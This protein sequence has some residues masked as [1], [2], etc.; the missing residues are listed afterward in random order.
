MNGKGLRKSALCI[1]LGMCLS[2]A[3]SLQSAHAANN[4]GSLVGRTTPGAQV[5]VTSPDTG[6][7]RTVTADEQGNYRFPFLPVGNYNVAVSSDGA[8]VGEARTVTISLGN[9]TNLTV[10][11]ATDLAAVQVL[12]SRVISPIDVTSTESATNITRQEVARLPVQRDI[13]DVATLAPGVNRGEFGGISFGGSSVAEN[14][15]YINGLNVTDFYNRVG[16]SSLPFSFLQEFQIK[17]GGY[18]VE[19]GRTT[20]GVINA[21]TRSGSNEFHAGAD[22]V[23]DGLMQSEA[24]DHTGLIS[25]YDETEENNYAVWASGPIIKDRLF[26]FGIYEKRDLDGQNTNDG[27]TRFFKT[28]GNNDFWGAKLDWQIND[29]NLLELLAFSDK[30]DTTQDSYPF[31]HTT[32][33]RGERDNRTFNKNGGDN[34]ALTYTGYLT[35]ALSMKVLYGENERNASVNS[36]NDAACN[37]VQDRRVSADFIGCTSNT[38]VI[39]RTDTREAARIDFEWSLGEHLLRFGADHENN[40]SDY[41]SVYPGNGLRYEVSNIPASRRVNGVIVPDPTATAYVR[42]RQ[43]ANNGTFETENEA[44]YVEDNW[45]VTPNLVLNLGLRWEAFDNKD[46]EGRSYIEMDD[47]IAPRFGFSWDFN[48]DGRAKIF[49]NAGRYYLPVAN[50][51][52]IKQAGPFLDAR[53]FFVFQGFGTFTNPSTGITYP[54][55]ILGQEIGT[56]DDSQGDGT[57]GDLTGEVDQDMDPV[58]QD[59]YILGF[60]QMLGETWSWGVRGIYR[61]LHDAIDDMEITYNGFCEVDTFVMANPGKDLTFFTDTD[62]D[63]D[64]DNDA[65]VTIDTSSQGWALYND[66]GDLVGQRGWGQAKRT[67]RALEFVL[68]RAWDD[69]WAFNASYTLSYSKG[70]AEGP[71]NSDTDFADSGRTE[72]FDNPFVNLDGYGYLPNDHRHQFKFRAS[73]ALADNWLLGGTLDAQSGRPVSEFGAGNPIDSTEFL[74]HYICEFN[75]TEEFEPSERIYRLSPRG[76]YDRLPWAYSL[77]A[78]IA[79]NRDFGRVKMNAKFA[80]YNITNEQTVTEVNETRE[81]QD[82]IGTPNPFFFQGTGYQAPRYAQFILSINY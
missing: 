2:S 9:A 69:K 32:G 63:C 22:L 23:F 18:S 60:Q 82:G 70:N 14:S 26:F 41:S 79:Y 49:G 48:G 33:D 36:L 67:Y 73:Y 34:W 66:D 16:F 39:D 72:A 38:A 52:N 77:G 19:F 76:A 65:M 78:S 51:I 42:T 28:D 24:K 6:F 21:V 62:P 71:V 54:D 58:Y 75:C 7:T 55:P 43:V 45:S 74:S 20:G 15:V 27:G 44:Y 40:T 35:D 56:V 59:E 25:R 3:L 50:V 81:E 47:M 46:A 1:A 30:N 11:S 31:D 68:D 53:R 80:I 8:A 10:A 57:V 13:T 17:T 5:T 61:K 29:S 64:G 12:G 4:D 37:L